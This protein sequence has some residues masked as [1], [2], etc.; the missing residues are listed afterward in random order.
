MTPDDEI[1]MLKE[2]RNVA[3]NGCVTL[4]FAIDRVKALC[5]RNE[6]NIQRLVRIAE[7]RAALREPEPTVTDDSDSAI[8]RRLDAIDRVKALAQE[9]QMKGERLQQIPELKLVGNA[10]VGM[11][12]RILKA[13]EEPEAEPDPEDIGEVYKDSL[14]REDQ[15]AELGGAVGRYAS[16]ACKQ[17][18]H[19]A[20]TDSGCMCR[21]HGRVVGDAFGIDSTLT[22]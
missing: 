7:V 4:G 5:D 22:P 9:A 16:F 17:G 12:E 13:L 14:I 19:N 6:G 2:E 11:S 20:C 3:R 8:I 18:Y 15:V 1:A 21:H 10:Y